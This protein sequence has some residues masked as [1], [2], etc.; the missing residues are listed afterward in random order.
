MTRETDIYPTLRKRCQIANENKS[1][2]FISVHCNSVAVNT[3]A[4]GIET[5]YFDTSFD[6]AS[7]AAAV[8]VKL[9]RLTEAV[10]RGV[11]GTTELYVL[12]NTDM[13]AILVECGFMSTKDD[14]NKLIDPHYQAILGTS[15]ASGI[16]DYF[17]L[18][19]I[20][21]G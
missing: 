5:W 11:K 6:G 4:S 15:I 13:P 2:V 16:E 8:M 17:N 21:K 19:P 12:K 18:K 10:N 9:I 1:D 7:L 20:K 14:L 3:A